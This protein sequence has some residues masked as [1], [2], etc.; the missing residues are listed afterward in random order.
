MCFET[1]TTRSRGV[2][3]GG[4]FFMTGV[5][6]YVATH[7]VSRVSWEVEMVNTMA[8]QKRNPF[9]FGYRE[10]E[11]VHGELGLDVFWNIWFRKNCRDLLREMV[12]HFTGV[13]RSRGEG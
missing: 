9:Q 7:Q 10:L 2:G 11:K 4:L 1:F 6:Q 3:R 8:H 12:Q 5:P 13:Y